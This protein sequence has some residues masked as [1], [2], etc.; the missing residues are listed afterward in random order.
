[1]ALRIRLTDDFRKHFAKL[2]EKERARTRKTLNLLVL[3]PLYHAL[4]T[5]KVKGKNGIFECSVNM[6]IRILWRYEGD[7]MIIAL[8]IGHHDIL[9]KV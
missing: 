1:M 7:A 8:D 2:N 3:N 4:R 9:R 6:D 5:K